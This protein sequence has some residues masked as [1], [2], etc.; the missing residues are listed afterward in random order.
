MKKLSEK[1]T[2]QEM[3]EAYQA[4]ARQLEEKRA[5]ELAPERRLEEKRAEEAVRAASG[6]QPEGID[7]E[8]GQ[9]KSDIGKLLADVSE[10]LGTESARFRN[11][12]KAVE[13]KEAELRELYGIEKSA[14]SL[15]ALLE[16]QNQ[17]RL[18]FESQI[19]REREELQTEMET[20][21]AEWEEEKKAHDAEIRERDAAD[22]RAQERAREDFNYTFKR[23][24]QGLKDK[25]AD[26]K[27]ALEKEIKLRRETAEKDLAEREK[28]LADREREL[29]ELRARAAAFPKEI[30]TALNQATKE[31]ADRLKLE[32]KNREDG[33]VSRD[34]ESVAASNNATAGNSR[35]GKST[36]PGRDQPE[37]ATVR[38]QAYCLPRRSG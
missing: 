33:N 22:K 24:Q 29:A 37:G 23:E 2:K 36:P 6:V 38:R 32:A 11:I 17:K 26:E 15:A 1:S 28:A 27:A 31:T 10:R 5:A 18:E 34:L 21:R 7:R 12:Q 35:R 4:L 30:E 3:L 25:L 9:L 20:K 19:A 14:V 8:I 16:A 13:S